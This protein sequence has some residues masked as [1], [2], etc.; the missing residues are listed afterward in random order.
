M[1]KGLATLA[2]LVLFIAVACSADGGTGET[3]GGGASAAAGV[4]GIFGGDQTGEGPGTEATSSTQS[5]DETEGSG[6]PITVPQPDWGQAAP[7]DCILLTDDATSFAGSE[8][9]DS[10]LA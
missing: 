2:A 3:S 9:C 8:P 4:G 1:G 10:G 6:P 5:S 7:G